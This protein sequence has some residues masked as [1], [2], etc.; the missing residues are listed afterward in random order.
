[1]AYNGRVFRGVWEGAMSMILRVAAVTG[2][3]LLVA[4]GGGSGPGSSA[5]DP[6][7]E[8][9]PAADVQGDP[10]GSPD[11]AADPGVPFDAP[12]VAP[13]AGTR[14][15]Q[16]MIYAGSPW[17]IF[18]DQFEPYVDAMAAAGIDG[19]HVIGLWRMRCSGCQ[20]GLLDVD[21]EPAPGVYDF[22]PYFARLDYAIGVRHMPVILSFMWAGRLESDPVDQGPVPTLPP[23]LGIDD[24]AMFRDASG[25]DLPYENDGRT[26]VPRFLKGAVRTVM[27]DY[28][29]AVVRQF[30]ARYGDAIL[31]YS[32]A[33]NTT[34]ENEFSV[35]AP[36]LYLDSSPEAA[37]GFQAFVKGR[38]P[39]PEA[40]STAWGRTPAFATFDEVRILDGNPP[41][42]SGQ[43][44]QAYLDF[45]AY[46]EAALGG[47]LHDI[48][49][50]VHAEGGRVMAQFGSVWDGLATGR[51]TLGFGPMVEG[52]D[53]V[54]VDD[55]PFYD[56]GFSMD[57]VRTNADGVP[58]GNE[59]DTP[60]FLG[61]RSGDL[62]KCQ[63]D[64]PANIDADYGNVRLNDQMAQTYNRGG[65]FFDI[66][67]WDPYYQVAFKL[68]G[69]ALDSTVLAVAQPV[70]LVPTPTAVQTLSLRDLYVHHEDAAYWTAVLATH[71]S[72]GGKTA[73]IRVTLDRD[74]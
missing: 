45:M 4:C 32:F 68:F 62:A 26:K 35:P 63:A 40:V 3:W 6:F 31:Y 66:A 47:F 23:F 18:Q 58:F 2:A 20:A 36:G 56:H 67:N 59:A 72:L 39:S 57:Y 24:V 34:G 14:L 19:L 22:S 21:T 13:A 52:F 70:T 12:D 49:D 7:P 44:P 9:G 11:D 43:A 65:T 61:C 41:P 30:R 16:N 73:P 27:L 1:M 10:G 25:R 42:T 28:V 8:D 55:A 37:A 60:A 74:L 48:R 69:P 71:A 33:F 54:V 15:F 53:L 51:G 29:S 46:R 5:A 38:Y 17:F 64:F 50:R